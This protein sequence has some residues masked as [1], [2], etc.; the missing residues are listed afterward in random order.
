M[1]SSS[2]TVKSEVEMEV[3]QVTKHFTEVFTSN[4]TWVLDNYANLPN[5]WLYTEKIDIP[6]TCF[7]W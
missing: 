7:Y 5:S 2:E 1:S 6:R 3:K 4:F